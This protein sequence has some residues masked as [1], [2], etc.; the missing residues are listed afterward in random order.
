MGGRVM[1]SQE[2]ARPPN[3]P[4]ARE[5][6]PHCSP[7]DPFFSAVIVRHHLS[8]LHFLGPHQCPIR[9]EPRMKRILFFAGRGSAGGLG[10]AEE[11]A[12]DVLYDWGV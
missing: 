11:H 9:G 7:S 1:A 10:A 3:I 2:R 5:N 8:S 4:F 12:V 6:G